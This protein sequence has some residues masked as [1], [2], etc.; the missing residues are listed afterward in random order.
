[1]VDRE[2]KIYLKQ[3]EIKVGFGSTGK[4]TRI[5]DSYQ[6]IEIDNNHKEAEEFLSS[7]PFP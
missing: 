7:I 2:R 3:Q 4:T 1:M 6:V 5:E